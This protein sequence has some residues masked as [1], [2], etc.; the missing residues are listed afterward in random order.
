MGFH[1]FP[2]DKEQRAVWIQAIKREEGG[3]FAVT[4]HTT[5]SSEHFDPRCY[6]ESKKRKRLKHESRPTKFIFRKEANDRPTPREQRAAAAVHVAVY[7]ALAKDKV[8]V[9]RRGE[10][11]EQFT[12][13]KELDE[14]KQTVASQEAEITL[15]KAEVQH[16]KSQ[17][18]IF[19]HL[20]LV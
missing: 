10:T 3:Y 14:A 11:V 4:S 6:T 8:N 2:E 9:P 13:R 20:L 18:F 7:K 19:F 17:L 12:R 15:L 5:V 16:L 1:H